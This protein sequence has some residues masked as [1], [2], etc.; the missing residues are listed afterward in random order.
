MTPDI[1]I[2][3]ARTSND[4]EIPTGDD[5][6]RWIKHVLESENIN[7]QVVVRIVDEEEI[8]QLNHDYRGQD[9]PTNVLSFAYEDD[10]WRPKEL[11]GD[12]V[13]CADV[14][15]RE[16]EQSHSELMHHW[17][18]LTMHGMLHLLGYDHVTDE[19]ASIME[20]REI[21]LLGKMNISNPYE[22]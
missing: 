15:Q 13:I 17:A 9:K 11:L 19:Q 21:D 3:D 14:V 8:R 16:A 2:Q 6:D 18:H 20:A 1:L 5:F 10:E 12:L 7:G 4:A 22:T